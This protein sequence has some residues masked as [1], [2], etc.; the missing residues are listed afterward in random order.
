MYGESDDQLFAAVV[1]AKMSF[2]FGGHQTFGINL[3]KKSKGKKGKLETDKYFY[4]ILKKSRIYLLR[5][6][7]IYF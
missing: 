7:R 6:S 3:K 2:L 4:K 5:D 1:N